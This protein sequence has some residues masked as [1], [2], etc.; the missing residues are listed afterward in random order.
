MLVSQGLLWIVVLLLAGAVV[1]LAR[2]V[3]VLHER[4]APMGALALGQGP[5]PGEAAPRLTA[6]ALDG[7]PVAIGGA[8][9]SGR[10]QLLFFVAPSCP[11]CKQLLPTARK[12]ADV[13]RLDLLLVGDG[14]AE[15]HREMARRHGID[16]A[17]FVN[18]S[19][20]GQAFRV[21]KLPY[22]VLIDPR[23]T[24]VAQ[25]L[26]NTREH[27]E[28]LLNVQE[29]GFASVQDY[30]RARKSDAHPVEESLTHG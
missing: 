4:I 13:E 27:L 1:A 9:D 19:A 2:Q 25:G 16:E 24:V 14:D 26:V 6:A 30:L 21:G 17:A 5:Q 29:T 20:V 15:Q 12:F 18:S 22:S 8:R 7:R 11:I 10:M 23:G 3:G 28:S